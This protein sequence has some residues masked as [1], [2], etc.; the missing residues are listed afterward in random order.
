MMNVYEEIKAERE[1][2]DKKW[3]IA[4]DDKNTLNDW[5]TYINIYAA[6]A[7]AMGNTKEEQRKQMVKVA[8]LTVAALQSFDRNG[9][10]APRHYDPD[11]KTHYTLDDAVRVIKDMD[12]MAQTDWPFPTAE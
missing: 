3:G 2:Q 6:K 5:I 12:L 8:A 1:Y 11:Y 10:F 7:A 4:F 9:G